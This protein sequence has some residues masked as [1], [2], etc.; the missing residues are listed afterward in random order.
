VERL[1]GIDVHEMQLYR[2]L[3]DHVIEQTARLPNRD[4]GADSCYMPDRAATSYRREHVKSSIAIEAIDAAGE[5]LRYFPWPRLLR[6]FGGTTTAACSGWTGC[7]PGMCCR[8]ML[9]WCASMQAPV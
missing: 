3:A 2:P 6:T 5:R 8:P 1:Y 4:Y 9:R 7:L